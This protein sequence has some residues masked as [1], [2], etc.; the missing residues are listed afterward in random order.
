MLIFQLGSIPALISAAVFVGLIATAGLVLETP[1]AAGM[2]L[3][4]AISVLGSVLQGIMIIMQLTK[5]V[6]SGNIKKVFSYVS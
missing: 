1:V 6:T 5:C 4:I 3:V 2:G